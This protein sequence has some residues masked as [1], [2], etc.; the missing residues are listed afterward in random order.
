[1][2]ERISDT[3]AS[4]SRDLPAFLPNPQRILL[5]VLDAWLRSG[6]G[7]VA[8]NEAVVLALRHVLNEHSGKG[9]TRVESIPVLIRNE[10]PDLV[11]V[12]V[13]AIARG[14]SSEGLLL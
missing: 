6:A 3:L 10:D 8:E 12:N 2:S 9:A 11:N 1:M 5:W 13:V 14:P 4:E 7:N